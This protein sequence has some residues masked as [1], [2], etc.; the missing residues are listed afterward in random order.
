RVYDIG[1]AEGRTFLSME[2]ID[3]EDLASLLR[4]IG[5]LPQDKALDVARQLC[6]GLAAA[7]DKG[8]IHRDLKPANVMLDEVFSGRPA[9]QATTIAEIGRLH[10]ETTPVKLSSLVADLDPLVDH[11]VFHCLAKN[12]GL[13]PSSALAVS[14]ALPGGDP[15]AAA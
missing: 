13:R 15:L 10:S 4:R 3:G 12:P 2:Y 5:R 14:A 11:I 6:A 9:L 1:E 8:V 7:H